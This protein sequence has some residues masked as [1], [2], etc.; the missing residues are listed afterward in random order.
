MK[1]W[2]LLKRKPP[3]RH[4][5][6]ALPEAGKPPWAVAEWEAKAVEAQK[7]LLAAARAIGVCAELEYQT[8]ARAKQEWTDHDISSVVC[9]AYLSLPN[10][11]REA[12]PTI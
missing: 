12:M 3:P 4:W 5:W 8:V 11:F 2:Q 9:D 6:Y 1:R 7:H 10:E